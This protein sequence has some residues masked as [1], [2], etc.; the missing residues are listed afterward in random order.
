[1][2]MTP[3]KN[4]EIYTDEDDVKCFRSTCSCGDDNHDVTVY[5]D[6]HLVELE[7][8]MIIHDDYSENIFIRFLKRISLA[9]KIVFT[10]RHEI[11]GEFIFKD[12]KHVKNF[13]ETLEEAYSEITK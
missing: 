7:F 12:P 8:K 11:Y 4:I 6:H 10:G 5:I 13:T 2:C 9:M 3:R 1:M